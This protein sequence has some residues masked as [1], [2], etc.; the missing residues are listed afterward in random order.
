MTSQSFGG[1]GTEWRARTWASPKVELR[2]G[3]IGFGVIAREAIEQGETVIAPAHVFVAAPHRHTIQLD[4]ELHQAGTDEI[5]DYL[6]HA[7]AP[8]LRLDGER[9]CFVAVRPIAAGEQLTFNYLTSEWDMAEAFNCNCGAP[10]C[11][12]KIRGF[13]HL[14]PAQQEALAP[15]LTPFL[16]RMRGAS[17][18]TAA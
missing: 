16:R 13:R 3:E 10:S 15:L 4:A 18:P 2:A 6:N 11:F 9:L 17:L 1:E 7:C 14:S 5:D 12:G 8:N